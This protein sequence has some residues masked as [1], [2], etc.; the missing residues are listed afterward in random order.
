VHFGFHEIS[1]QVPRP[2][3]FDA[4]L[5]SQSLSREAL[6]TAV[7]Q[8]SPA[9]EPAT[10]RYAPAQV[11]GKVEVFTVA[12]PGGSTPGVG[13]INF[14]GQERVVIVSNQVRVDIT[15]HRSTPD[16]MLSVLRVRFNFIP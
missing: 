12:T 14:D 6:A 9:P 2:V 13:L 7:A 11:F 16:V 4:H 3:F 10:Q 15:L 8:T 5:H 1:S